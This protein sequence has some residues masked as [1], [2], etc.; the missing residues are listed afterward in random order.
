MKE[1][2]SALARYN[3]GANEKLVSLLRGPSEDILTRNEGVY[4]KS[5]LGTVEHIAAS[6]ISMLRRFAGFFHYESLAAHRLITGDLDAIKASF[7]DAPEALYAVLTEV[8]AL[9]AEYVAEVRADDL[10]KR[11]SYVNYKG[12]K[13]E[14]SYWNMIVHILNHGTHHRGEISALLDRAGVANDYSGFNLYTTE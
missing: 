5:I 2:L 13:L 4:Y 14:R 3:Q 10:T 6:E 1:V 12:E 8:D 7:R 9:M 11:V